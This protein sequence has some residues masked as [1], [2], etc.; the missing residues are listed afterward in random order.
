MSGA[1]LRSFIP[2][3]RTVFPTHQTHDPSES[4]FGFIVQE[5]VL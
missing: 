3:I 4:T 2:I 5:R 1:K